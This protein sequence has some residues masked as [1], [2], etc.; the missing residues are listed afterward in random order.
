MPAMMQSRVVAGVRGG[1]TFPARLASGLCRVTALCIGA[2][3][4]ALAQSPDASDWGYYGGDAFGPRFSSL[5]EINPSNV[6][7][8]SGAWTYCTAPRGAGLAPAARLTLQ[9]TPV[10]AFGLFYPET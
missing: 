8:L 9:A 6:S 2:C 4:V 1:A 5:D 3:A 7:K 10:L